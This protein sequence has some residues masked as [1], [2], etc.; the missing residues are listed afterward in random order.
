MRVLEHLAALKRMQASGQR[1]AVATLVAVEGSAPREPGAVM[2]VSDRGELLGSISGGCVEAAIA[3]EARAVLA[4]SGPRCLRF[5]ISDTQAQ[6]VGLS[7]GGELTVLID[8]PGCETFEEIAGMV[9][10]H[11]PIASALRIDP[12]GAGRR[13][14]VALNA[15]AGSLGTPALDEHVRGELRSDA[16]PQTAI[17]CYGEDGEPHGSVRIFVQRNAPKPHMYV[18][19]AIDFAAAMIDMGRFLGYFVTLCDARAAFATRERFPQADR[20]CVEW[21]HEFLQRERVDADTAIVAFTHDEKFDLPLLMQA[22]RGPACYIGIMGSRRTTAMRID[23]LRN[24]GVDEQ[25]LGRLCAPIGLD[26]GARTPRETAVAI[27]AEIVAL[28]NARS[29][30]RL[31][32]GSGTLRGKSSSVK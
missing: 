8:E 12:A 17:R 4:G 23:Q 19:G 5:G 24:A 18:F 31:T 16:L 10:V 15:H 2:A 3:D 11:T 1:W 6:S 20:I 9:A 29:G 30:A 26:I 13:L 32:G 27:A 14:V 22:L 21:P 25:A 7:C 28:R